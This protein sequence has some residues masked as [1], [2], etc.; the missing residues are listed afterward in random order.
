MSTADGGQIL[1][2]YDELKRRN[3]LRVVV[4]YLAGAWLLLQVV[5]VLIDNTSL[6]DW[7]FQSTHFWFFSQLTKCRFVCVAGQNV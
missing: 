3:V 4:A 7:M 2:F 1:S 6:P 5:D